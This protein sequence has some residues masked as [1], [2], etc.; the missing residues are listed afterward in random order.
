MAFASKL[1]SSRWWQEP[2]P[3]VHALAARKVKKA[4]P[5]SQ[6]PQVGE[7]LKCE[8]GIQ[9]GWPGPKLDKHPPRPTVTEYA[10]SESL[11]CP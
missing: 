1:T 10:V 5:G 9:R 11:K 8:K 7:V 2:G 4:C 3:H 6:D